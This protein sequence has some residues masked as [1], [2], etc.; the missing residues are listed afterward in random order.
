MGKKG[1]KL[2]RSIEYLLNS[3]EGRTIFTTILIL[4]A[5]WK[6]SNSGPI[7]SLIWQIKVLII[8]IN[9]NKFHQISIF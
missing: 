4:N 2:R 8:N 3:F 7:F 1:R 5:F 9:M 6:Y